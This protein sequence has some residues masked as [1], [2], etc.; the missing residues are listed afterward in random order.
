LHI[1]HVQFRNK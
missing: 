1:Y